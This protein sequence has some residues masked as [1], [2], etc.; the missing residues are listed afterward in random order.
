MS[1]PLIL[2][3]TNTWLAYSI[4][5][6]YYKESHYVWCAPVFD[7]TTFPRLATVIPPT[8]SPAEI[9]R[10][11]F[12]EVSRGDRHSDKIK[13]NK[14]GII[15]GA[16]IRKSSGQISDVIEKDIVAIVDSAETRDFR[17]LLFVIPFR[18]VSKIVMEVPVAERAHP[19]SQ[20]YRIERLPRRYFDVIEFNV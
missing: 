17:P 12:H 8:S 5:Q 2:Y 14:I 15:R 3:S 13:Q 9:Y 20:E 16:S 1:K 18:S 4:A 19:L 11:L 10:N 7:A 6:R